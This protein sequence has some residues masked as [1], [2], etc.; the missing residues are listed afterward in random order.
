MF[1]TEPSRSLPITCIKVYGIYENLES[2]NSD[3]Y[4][5]STITLADFRRLGKYQKVYRGQ[6]RCFT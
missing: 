5:F 4:R 2:E 3:L 6:F 1:Q